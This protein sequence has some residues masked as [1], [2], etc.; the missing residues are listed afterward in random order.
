[1]PE[2]LLNQGLASAVQAYCE[3]MTSKGRTEISFQAIGNRKDV[4]SFFDLPVYRIIQELVHNVIKHAH[5]AHALVQI[6]FQDDG[7]INITV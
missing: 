7:N 3:K 5:A 4:T 1:M 6:N 2:V